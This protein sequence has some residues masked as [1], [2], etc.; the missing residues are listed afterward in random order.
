M[1]HIEKILDDDGDL[2]V[3]TRFK[4]E[5]TASFTI[6]AL[7]SLERDRFYD[8]V[9]RVLAFGNENPYTNQFRQVLE[10]ND[11]IAVNAKFDEISVGGN[12][13]APGTP[14]GTDEII[15]ETTV[16][17]DLVGEF[18]ADPVAQALVLLSAIIVTPVVDL[19]TP[20]GPVEELF[21]ADD[22]KG[23]WM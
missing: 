17:L 15:Y 18:V 6:V 5:G 3:G 4:F 7:T 16:S 21:P 14:W 13:S 2:R 20:T 12:A 11:L 8:E 19:T 1:A 23:A 9:I 10:D 22:G